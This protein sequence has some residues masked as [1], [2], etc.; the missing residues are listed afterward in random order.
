MKKE[1]SWCRPFPLPDENYLAPE[2]TP[3]SNIH[4]TSTSQNLFITTDRS[5][6]TNVLY[7][8]SIYYPNQQ[9][10]QNRIKLKFKNFPN[11]LKNMKKENSWCRPFPL[12]DENYLAPEKTP[13]SNI[14]SRL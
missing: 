3:V 12:P 10:R 2:K 6:D 14:R 1:N 11:P 8:L 13:V 5:L 4:L 7:F 9:N